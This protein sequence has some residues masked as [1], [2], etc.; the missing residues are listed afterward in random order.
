VNG[1]LKRRVAT[2]VGVTKSWINPDSDCLDNDCA[3][4]HCPAP[5]TLYYGCDEAEGDN[6]NRRISGKC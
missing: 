4:N 3:D 6:N 5:V 1:I 2:A